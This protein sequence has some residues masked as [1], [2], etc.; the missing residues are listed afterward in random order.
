MIAPS[1]R[2]M[3]RIVTAAVRAPSADN[4][5]PWRFH[6]DGTLSILHDAERAHHSLDLGW[7][8]SDLALGCVLESLQVAAAAEGLRI[9]ERLHLEVPVEPRWATVRFHPGD[10]TDD[11]LLRALERRYVDR[12]LYRG[13]SAAHPV[14][15]RVRAEVARFPAC[16]VHVLGRLPEELPKEL[17][18]FC[19]HADAFFW[20]T[21]SVYRDTMRWLRV[22]QREV[23]ETRDGASWRVLGVDLPELKMMQALRSPLARRVL[24]RIGGRAAMGLWTRRQ[25]ASSAVLVLFTV[26]APRRENLVAVGRAAMAAWLR[27]TE[28][29]H[30]VQPHSLWS[31]LLLKAATGTLPPDTD[32]S[33]GPLLAEGRE[34]V[35]RAFG[36]DRDELPVWMLRTGIS[37]FLPEHCR[38]LRRPLDEVFTV[39]DGG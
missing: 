17:I 20:R 22:T 33:F 30:G 24:G 5:Q 10:T 14:F 6:W 15:D 16:G 35:A 31:L 34:I 11:S 21:E 2:Q 37:S 1:L 12:R 39:A 27:L 26:R 28:A 36:L 7:H 23:E 13:G 19:V 4:C 29:D 18:D 3:R 8:D 32:P 25:L 38:T 9:E